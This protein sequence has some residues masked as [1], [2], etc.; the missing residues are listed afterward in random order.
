MAAAWS[1]CMQRPLPSSPE[2]GPRQH[3][4]V[5]LSPLPLF[6]RPR[7]GERRSSFNKPVSSLWGCAECMHGDEQPHPEVALSHAFCTFL[8]L[9]FPPE[10]RSIPTQSLSYPS[11]DSAHA[12]SLALL[13][14]A[15]PSFARSFHSTAGTMTKKILIICTS[16]DKL[17]D[18]GGATGSW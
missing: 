2:L 1:N 16:H 5:L 7:S 8:R 3:G 18:T 12:L 17:G 10:A 13:R 14:T 9:R 11:Q 15:L 4:L 6:P